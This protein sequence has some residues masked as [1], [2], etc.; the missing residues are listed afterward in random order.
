MRQDTDIVISGGGVAGLTAACLLGTAGFRVVILDPAPPVTEEA[1]AAADLRTTAFLQPARALLDR[2]GLWPALAPHAAP[3]QVM[4]IVDAG[5]AEPVARQV[6]DFEASEIGDLPFGWNLPNWLLR[7]EMVAR[8]EGLP[9]VD[10]RPGTAT[11]GLLTREAEALVTLSDGSR[12]RCALVVAADG[13]DS[14]MRR[15]AGIDV[16][17]TRYG[18]KALAFAVT[19]PI[20]H[21]GV[22][23]EIHRSGGPFT[24]V[25][26]PD[27][28]GR[29]ASAVVW[30]EDGPEAVRLAGLDVAAFESEMFT[31]SAGLFGPLTLETRRTVWPIVTQVAERMAGRRIV[32]M[33]EAA[34]VM[35][36]IGA[37]GLNTSLADLAALAGLLETHGDDPGSAA[38]TEGYDRARR[39]EVAIRAGG[40]D[41]LNRASRVHAEP[42][43]DLRAAGL[44][45]LHGAAPVRRMLM[46]LGLGAG[47]RDGT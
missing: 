15:A 10:F 23:T 40:I 4:R 22:S 18:Q 34:H 5:G 44:A 31:R 2:A 28:D 47:R 7:R 36:P 41:L 24:L 42:L 38:V 32:L 30:M 45:A 3:L 8:I 35:P 14:P 39:A 33:A 19:H 43:R 46:E 21:E 37:Q 27:R 9:N 29:P 6:R 12:L 17:I 20:P 16:R 11:T 13:R 25:P 1:D 26:L